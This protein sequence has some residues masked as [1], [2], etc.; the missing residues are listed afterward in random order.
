MTMFR[1]PIFTW[2]MLVTGILILIAFP[3]FTSALILL[4]CDRH[5][6]AHIFEVSGGGVPV[7]WQDSS[8]SSVI[9]RYTS[10]LCRSSGS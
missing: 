4:W 10:S 7:L 2:N 1:M 5:L 9:P 6:G 3:V 8:G